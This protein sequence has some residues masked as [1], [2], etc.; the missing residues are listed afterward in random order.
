ML[1]AEAK[2]LYYEDTHQ[3]TTIYRPRAKEYR[4]DYNMWQLITSRPVRPM[5]T[6]VL[7]AQQKHEVLAD[8]NEYLHP[9]TPA[10]YASRGIPLRRG[11]LF[12]GPPGT[13]KTLVARALAASC[14]TGGTKICPSLPWAGFA[15]DCAEMTSLYLLVN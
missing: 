8:I 1:L 13:G 9:S 12:H 10:W 7:D 11:Y 15:K 5:R 14:S 3:R 6:V 2:A 4:R